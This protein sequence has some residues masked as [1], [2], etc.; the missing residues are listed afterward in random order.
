MKREKKVF[1]RYEN[2]EIGRNKFS[3][4]EREFY[5]ANRNCFLTKEAATAHFEESYNTAL[6]RYKKIIA[7]I[8][9]LK[10]SLGDFS[11]NYFLLGDT[12]GIY[13][14]GLFIEISVNGYDF[15]FPQE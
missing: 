10:E 14:E 15:E 12:H 4:K 11:Y 5:A 3:I 7:G 9:K 1:Y 8:E 6:D 2:D 13:D